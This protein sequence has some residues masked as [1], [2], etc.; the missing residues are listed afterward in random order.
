MRQIDS[1]RLDSFSNLKT[2]KSQRAESMNGIY[3][4]LIFN[5]FSLARRVSPL[6]EMMQFYNDQF[7]QRK[8]WGY[9][10]HCLVLGKFVSDLIPVVF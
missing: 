8:L 1:D 6:I 4:I 2:V 3:F 7:D 9:G 5:Q 10:C